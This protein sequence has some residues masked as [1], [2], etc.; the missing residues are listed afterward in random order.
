MKQIGH[1]PAQ[2]PRSAATFGTVMGQRVKNRRQE[3]TLT[4]IE[5]RCTKNDRGCWLW[6]GALNS[7]GYGHAKHKGRTAEVHRLALTLATRDTPV[8]HEAAHGECHTRHCCNP[9]HLAWK[10]P[11]ENQRDRL[12]D[13]THSRGERSA[14]AKLTTE[15]VQYIRSVYT[16]YSREYGPAALARKYG[17]TP[18]CISVAARGV[19]WQHLAT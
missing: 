5:A 6:N 14:H 19:K 9:A 16:P 1:R 13:G 3:L 10:T 2:L 18:T 17:V 8:G 4:E 12:R 11:T 7:S 15:Q